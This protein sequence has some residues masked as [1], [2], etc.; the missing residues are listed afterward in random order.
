MP[1]TKFDILV[2]V[3]VHLT[4]Q[5]V[6]DIMVSALEG[7]INYWCDRVTVDG[8]YLGEYAS[9]QISRG[10]KLNIHLIEPFDEYDTVLYKLDIEKFKNGFKL[11][12]ENGGYRYG[13]IIGALI[14]DCKVNCG[15]IDAC[16]ADEIIQYALFG[17]LIFC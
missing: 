4:K 9:D 5:D 10:G 15:Q 6:D 13:S 8:E 17:D 2:M 11:W 3:H 7:G 12:L 14:E 16:C 1:E